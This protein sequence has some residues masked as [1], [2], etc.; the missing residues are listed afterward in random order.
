MN[1]QYSASKKMGGIKHEVIRH[2][3][4]WYT[5]CCA[6]LLAG[7][8]PL[9]SWIKMLVHRDPRLNLYYWLEI[10]SH[11]NKVARNSY[12]ALFSLLLYFVPHPQS[13]G[14]SKSGI[15]FSSPITPKS[16]EALRP[17]TSLVAFDTRC[18]TSNFRGDAEGLRLK[19]V[20]LR[21]ATR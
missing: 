6:L 12:R 8:L 10:V 3:R 2:I 5:F 14:K 9:Q 21:F 15:S 7:H 13:A 17:T 19:N 20:D 11:N 4:L 18:D 1:L 16:T